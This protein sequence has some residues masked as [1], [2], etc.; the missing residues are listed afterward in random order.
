MTHGLTRRRFIAV[1]GAAAGLATAGPGRAAE[2]PAARR[3]R[4]VALGAPAE[5]TL[6][7][8]DAAVADR[9]IRL[10]RNEIARLERVFSLYRADSALS[11]LN[12]DGALPDPPL[13]LVRLM[14]D[15]L[16]FAELTRGAFDP[17]VQPLWRLYADHFAQPDADP[18]G[19]SDAAIAAARVLVDHRQVAL[20]SRRIAFARP[21]MAVTLN[22]IAQGY[23]T[24]RVAD[25]LRD[26]GIARVMIDLGE[27]RALGRRPDGRPWRVGIANPLERNRTTET[28]DIVDRAVASSSPYGTRFEPTGAYHHLF[29]PATG[30]PHSPYRQV[31][32]T[33][34]RAT[35]ADALSTACA[36]MP[37]ART[38]ETLTGIDQVELLLTLADGRRIRK[39]A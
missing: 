29:D 24:D 37:P 5:I 4:G 2:A 34:P 27:I 10:C 35:V 16:A 32:V 1:A 21:G 38:E 31:T 8:P 18:A 11:A 19:P 6:Y 9:L 13:D 17:T 39:P 20:D 25:L 14:G 3:W 23:I 36:I 28:L 26:N 12:R 33:A 7:H 30:R 15:S 22:G